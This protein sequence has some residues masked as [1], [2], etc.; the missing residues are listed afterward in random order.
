MPD[1]ICP[2]CGFAAEVHASH[3]PEFARALAIGPQRS[4]IAPP[5]SVNDY[6]AG[7]WREDRQKR[8]G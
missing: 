8:P 2:H 5:I 4:P 3:C 1:E 7:S 6:V